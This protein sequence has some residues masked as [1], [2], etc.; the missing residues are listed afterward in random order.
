MSF[1]QTAKM[2]MIVHKPKTF[3]EFVKAMAAARP[4]DQK[5]Q[6]LKETWAKLQ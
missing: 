4:L 3:T 2:I 1:L 6:L 5:P